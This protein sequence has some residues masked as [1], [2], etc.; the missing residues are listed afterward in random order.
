MLLTDYF[1]SD[2]N[3]QWDYAKQCGVNHAVVRLP[4]TSDFDLTDAAHWADVYKRFTDYGITPV[5]IEPMPNAVHDHIKAGDALRDESIEKVIKMLP[6]MDSLDIRTICFNW[7]AHIGWY[8]TDKNIITRGG[9][10]VTGFDL[11][12][13]ENSGK[14]ITEEELWNNYRYF[15]DAVLPVAEKHNITLALHP[16]DPPLAKLGDVSRI[17]VSY[18]NINKAIRLRESDN[19]GLTMCQACFQMMGEDLHHVIPATADKIKFIHFRNASG[20]KYKFQ[21]KFHDDGDIDMADIMRLYKNLGIDV[22]VRIDHAP[23]MAGEE[24][25]APGYTFLG[26]LFAIGYL[27]G[28][29][30]V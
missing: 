5:I 17:M 16:D 9:A 22:P 3:I 8:R 21:E 28:L 11:T 25:S 14:V 4:E 26:R 18:E 10:K 27:K 24:N 1:L 20:N 6:I 12:K 29:L 7:M 13:F 23:V 15:I 19:L 2:I 30:E